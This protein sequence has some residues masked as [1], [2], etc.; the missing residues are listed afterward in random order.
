MDEKILKEQLKK[1]LKSELAPLLIG[2]RN[3]V[4]KI[5]KIFEK[6]EKARPDIQ[7][8]EITNHPE[9]PETQSV[10]V[11]NPTKEV[12]ITNPQTEIAVKG[13]KGL[14][15]NLY[16]K[17]AQGDNLLVKAILQVETALKSHIFK[18]QIQNQLKLPE[19]LK[20]EE[21]NKQEPPTVQRVKI[22]NSM[23]DEALP[24]KLT[25]RDGKKF[26]DALLQVTG[27]TNLQGV[28]KKLDEII[29]TLQNLDIT[30]NPGDISIGAVEL[31]DE[32]TDDRV[33]VTDDGGKNAV[34][35]QSN[36]LAQEATL[37]SA[38]AELTAIKGFVDGVEALLT[39][40]DG[41]DFATE[42][43][44]TA[45]SGFVDGIESLLTSIDGKD[46]ATETT[47]AALLACCNLI[48]GNTDQ[49]EAKLDTIIGLLGGA[50]GA[51]F[52]KAAEIT[53][54]GTTETDVVSFTVPAGKVACLTNI[55]IDGDADGRFK[56]KVGATTKWF[57]SIDQFQSSFHASMSAEGAAGVIMKV[58][59]ISKNSSSNKYRATISGTV[60]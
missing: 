18:V 23:P 29:T 10:H 55:T 36:S 31:K 39:S 42:T 14:F 46:F 1:A 21:Q 30:I 57:G 9:A 40:I 7:K 32:T 20:V 56:L 43:T 24:V 59:V 22:E 12:K 47:L 17:I 16:N 5:G 52:Q 37:A 50:T 34:F 28:K 25:T 35:V 51:T 60:I 13:I 44:L 53:T 49:L 58:T 41:K 38:L 33:N 4:E 3:E 26:Y 15:G 11:E 2:L 27:G 54:S 45:I 6:A 8:T 48:E 19:V